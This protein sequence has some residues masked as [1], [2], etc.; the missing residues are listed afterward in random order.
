MRALSRES[1]YS[2][3]PLF[4]FA[5]PSVHCVW[6]G[7]EN[8]FRCRYYGFPFTSS[9]A[10]IEQNEDGCV[11]RTWVEIFDEVLDSELK[12]YSVSIPA[13]LASDAEEVAQRLF[14]LL[15]RKWMKNGTK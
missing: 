1:S 9:L 10:Y 15:C 4:Q 13:R 5:P 6:D 14:K 3:L 7:N 11:I 8:A 12:E 2:R